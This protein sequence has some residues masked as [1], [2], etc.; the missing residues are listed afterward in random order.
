MVQNG[1]Q[2]SKIKRRIEQR[3][4]LTITKKSIAK[5]Q[6]K[7]KKSEVIIPSQ[8]AMYKKKRAADE[9]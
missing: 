3:T 4:A 2:L 5:K 1:R 6:Q 8:F 9:G 7:K